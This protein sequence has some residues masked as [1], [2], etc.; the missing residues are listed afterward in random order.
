MVWS[1]LSNYLL[2]G[3]TAD[4]QAAAASGIKMALGSDWAPSGSKSLL[5]ELKVAYLASQHAGSL[6][7]R[8]AGA[9]GHHQRG[10]D[11]GMAGAPGFYRAG[12]LADI[13]A[14]DGKAGDPYLQLITARDAALTLVVID[15]IPRVGQP[16][17]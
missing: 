11:I 3:G 14:I 10:R 16:I 4:I 13:I 5:G 1:P 9:H 8:A 15:G 6:F 7:C 17:S 12:K 2:Y